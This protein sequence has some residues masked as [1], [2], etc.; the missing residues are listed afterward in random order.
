MIGTWWIILLG[1]SWR[2][3]QR[4]GK[5]Y[6]YKY[7]VGAY[8]TSQRLF[9]NIKCSENL[10]VIHP[11]S[12]THLVEVGQAVGVL[13][14]ALVLSSQSVSCCYLTE[15]LQIYHIQSTGE[16]EG[17]T[18]VSMYT[19]TYLSTTHTQL[20]DVIFASSEVTG[21]VAGLPEAE[22]VHLSPALT[23]RCVAIRRSFKVKVTE[24]LQVGTH[25]L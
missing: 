17:Y 18:H 3:R 10:N 4:I 22:A 1:R 13:T 7:R 25:Y 11:Y 14:Q 8:L 15:L 21:P 23:E 2:E 20:P 9:G 16:T 24:L 19:H 6:K 5:Y 12:H